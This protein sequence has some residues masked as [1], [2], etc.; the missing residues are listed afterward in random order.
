MIGTKTERA[1]KGNTLALGWLLA[2]FVAA[3]LVLLTAGPAHAAT[4]TV[5]STSDR[6]DERPG[7][8]SCSTGVR[9]LHDDGFLELECT[10]RAAIQEA[11]AVAGAD[12]INFN[13]PGTGVKTISPRSSL[14][15]I[16]RPVVIDGYTQP[17]AREN[18]TATGDNAV[19]RIQ[20]TGDYPQKILAGLR[21]RTNNTTVRGLVVND[22]FTALVI[23][24]PDNALRGNFVG[25]DP[26]GTQARGNANSIFMGD[27]ASDNTI[28]GASPAAR[29]LVSG[30]S[31]GISISG[32]AS[33]SPTTG[34]RVFGNYIGTTRTGTGDLGNE[35]WGVIVGGSTSGNVIGGNSAAAANVIAFN[36]T[37]NQDG[38]GV[39]GETTVG[40]SILGNSIFSNADLGID[41]GLDGVTP[42]DAGDPD[43]GPNGLQ[44][45]PVITDAVTTGFT[46]TISGGLDSAPNR[47]FNLRFFSNPSGGEEGQQFMGQ[48]SVTTDANGNV[49]FTFAPAEKVSIGRTITATVTGPE[50]TSEFSAPRTVDAV[51][52][53]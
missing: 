44:N 33:G 43:T 6:G 42:D 19:L 31:Y 5:N 47:T 35:N 7:N 53:P 20:L 36:G 8:G 17:G 26:S 9:I 2:T 34:N 52:G 22:F 21:I 11:N 14:P 49:R 28:G 40:N 38:V 37:T 41:L 1:A 27:G 3:S 50:G 45:Y 23:L 29:N 46:T 15:D 51:I 24:G 48:Q 13:I 30:N 10:L 32:P 4:F 18:T 39:S 12:T 25:T 16:R